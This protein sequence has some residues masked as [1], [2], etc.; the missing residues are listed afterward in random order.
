MYKTEEFTAD[1][2]TEDYLKDFVDIDRFLEYCKDCPHYGLNWGCPPFDFDS[3][4]YW[5]NYEDL[6][7]IAIKIIFNKD[8]SNKTYTSDELNNIIHESIG[9]E[10]N[11]LVNT[12]VKMENEF[13]DSV[14]ISLGRCTLCKECSKKNNEKC[15][16]PD[17]LRH[18]MESLGANV[19][20]TITELLNIEMNWIEEYKL[21][22]YLVICAGLLYNS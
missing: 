9:N 10:K 17:K 13:E 7:I 18:S 22:N 1:I 8:V 14:Y 19:E 20:K 15:I 11:K 5:T 3:L 2:S 12:L 4:D 16:N 6:H 21:P